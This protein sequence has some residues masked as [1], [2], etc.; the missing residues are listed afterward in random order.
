MRK[1]SSRC[2]SRN[3]AHFNTLHVQKFYTITEF[4]RKTENLEKY[5]VLVCV[6]LMEA[7]VSKMRRIFLAK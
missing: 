1:I 4:E 3:G 2:V 7:D 6:F 5:V